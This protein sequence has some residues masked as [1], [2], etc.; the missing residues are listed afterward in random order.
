ME[1][2]SSSAARPVGKLL[3]L[4]VGLA[5]IGAA[6]CDPLQLAARPLTVIARRSRNEDFAVLAKLVQREDA[7]AVICGLPLNMDGS[8]GERARSVRK[9]AMRLAHALRALLGAPL[10]VI[11]WDER[12]ST[13]AAQS[14]LA[15]RG[16]AVAEDAAAAAVI[17]Q[18]Y[19]DARA[20]AEKM[21]YGRIDLAPRAV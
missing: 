8:E 11:F 4:D 16:D 2:P 3:A 20:M 14:I 7:Q 19:L 1:H 21:D 12:L 17:L 18:S 6:V 15:E 10:P 5:R 13:Y 9:W